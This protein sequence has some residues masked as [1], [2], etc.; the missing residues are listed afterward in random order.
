MALAPRTFGGTGIEVSPLTLGTMR[1]SEKSLSVAATCSLIAYAHERGVN[2]H[3]VSHEYQSFALYREALLS[4]PQSFRDSLVIIAKLPFPHFKGGEADISVFEQGVDRYREWLRLEKLDIV[5]W[6]FR[7]EPL[8]DSIRIPRLLACTDALRDRFAGLVRA[9]KVGAI[10]CFPYSAGFWRQAAKLGLAD[11]QVNY[12][13]LLETDCC[14]FLDC[15]FIAIRPLAAGKL[16]A[17]G[18]G[19]DPEFLE[20]LRDAAGV[21]DSFRAFPMGL[22]LNFPLWHPNVSSVVL[23]VRDA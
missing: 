6:L 2:T 15:P 9:R 8:D 17:R 21:A 23:S 20:M 1:F 14:E 3:H 4:F 19:V 13:N 18:G 11:S 5:Q 22:A 10:A 7:S 12:L 16:S